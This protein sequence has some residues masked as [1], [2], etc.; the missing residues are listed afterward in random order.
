MNTHQFTMNGL[1]NEIARIDADLATI[2]DYEDG[3]RAEREREAYENAILNGYA[4]HLNSKITLGTF[5]AVFD[6]NDNQI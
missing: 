1:K 3:E 5:D 6:G 2:T 4:F